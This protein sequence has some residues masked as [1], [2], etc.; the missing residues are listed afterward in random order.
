MTLS[1]WSCTSRTNSSDPRGCPLARKCAT[2]DS[3]DAGPKLAVSVELGATAARGATHPP[4]M[5][6]DANIVPRSADRIQKRYHSRGHR[7]R[8][9]RGAREPHSTRIEAASRLGPGRIL[10]SVPARQRRPPPLA[11]PTSSARRTRQ[12]SRQ[13]LPGPGSMHTGGSGWCAGPARM[14][15]PA[16]VG[17]LVVGRAGGGVGRAAGRQ[18]GGGW[19]ARSCLDAWGAVCGPGLDERRRVVVSLHS[20]RAGQ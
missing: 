14:R 2:Q 1:V 11:P 4:S 8:S 13:K 20:S 10:A 5:T 19:W 7:M 17:V 6:A 9:A 16:G 15:S 18:W 3:A 12:P